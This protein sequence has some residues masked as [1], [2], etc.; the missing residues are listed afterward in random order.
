MVRS[1]VSVRKRGQDG[2][3]EYTLPQRNS[4]FVSDGP[5]PLGVREGC[6]C[7]CVRQ[8][9]GRSVQPHTQRM[10]RDT[11]EEVQEHRVPVSLS[12]LSPHPKWGR[13]GWEP[14]RGRAMFLCPILRSLDTTPAGNDPEHHVLIVLT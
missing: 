9:L 6:V 13:K 2:P 11:E 12:L 5:Q 4:P 1:K 10:G 3:Q 14:G 8:G 7:V